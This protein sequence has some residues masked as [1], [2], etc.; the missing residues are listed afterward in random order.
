M[1]FILSI[2]AC[3]SLAVSSFAAP[4]MVR[5][6]QCSDAV[7]STTIDPATTIV[8]SLK[9]T[10]DQYTTAISTAH[11]AFVASGDAD[12]ASTAY[13]SA[14]SSLT[15]A[16]DDSTSQVTALTGV[17]V[18]DVKTADADCIA[19]ITKRQTDLITE[20]E[21]VLEELTTAVQTIVADLGLSMF[22]PVIVL[23][24]PKDY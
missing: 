9:S 14:I 21:A 19:S 17:S 16:F 2:A 3:A 1:K 13:Q 23:P 24:F 15:S 8:S 6:R 5:K 4:S 7:N 12:T 10:V 11:D 20:L 22:S 18:D